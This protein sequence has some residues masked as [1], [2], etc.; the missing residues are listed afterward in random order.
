MFEWVKEN[1]TRAVLLASGIVSLMLCG[2]FIDHME[3]GDTWGKIDWNEIYAAYSG[4]FALAALLS[5]WI[6]RNPR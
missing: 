5:V 3:T 1:K 4:G 6:L 2:Y